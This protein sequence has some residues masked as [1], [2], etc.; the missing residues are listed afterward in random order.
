MN[1]SSFIPVLS[2]RLEEI[3]ATKNMV[4]ISRIPSPMEKDDHG[5][6]NQVAIERAI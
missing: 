6:E 3:K 5:Y 1:P 4:S 2:K